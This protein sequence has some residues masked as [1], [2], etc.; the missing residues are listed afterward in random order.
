MGAASDGS[1][2]G[3]GGIVIGDGVESGAGASGTP[4][5]RITRRAIVVGLSAVL[6]VS[7][8][9]TLA[10]APVEA[11]GELVPIECFVGL[12]ES[13]AVDC[14]PAILRAA[15]AVGRGSRIG[16]SRRYRLASPV[17]NLTG[18]TLVGTA[19]KPAM[20]VQGENPYERAS[21]LIIAASAFVH[22]ARGTPTSPA[23]PAF[24]TGSGL[25][26]LSVLLEGLKLP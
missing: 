14:G 17:P 9:R 20:P 25:C 2:D 4:T 22:D 5:P 16:L 3:R 13:L 21:L 11:G 18:I 6:L 19:G 24:G 15:T 7:T 26:N 10:R 8:D 23:F 1:V 12:G